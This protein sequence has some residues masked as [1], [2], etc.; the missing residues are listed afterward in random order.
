MRMRIRT[1]T[2]NTVN[3]TRHTTTLSEDLPVYPPGP[4]GPQSGKVT[5]FISSEYGWIQ[6]SKLSWQMDQTGLPWM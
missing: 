4:L 3:P 5:L 1:R 2:H 6:E